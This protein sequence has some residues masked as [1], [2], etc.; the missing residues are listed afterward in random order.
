MIKLSIDA[1][2]ALAGELGE[3]AGTKVIQVIETRTRTFVKKHCFEAV[4]SDGLTMT[5]TSR[6]LDNAELTVHG[7]CGTP[8]D[9]VSVEEFLGRQAMPER[10]GERLDMCQEN[11]ESTSAQTELDSESDEEMKKL[12]EAYMKAEEEVKGRATVLTEDLE[13]KEPA[14]NGI[15]VIRMADEPVRIS[16]V[17][18]IGLTTMHSGIS[19]LWRL[20]TH[21]Q[22]KAMTRLRDGTQAG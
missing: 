7:R 22:L 1:F 15:S 4:F 6:K 21:E 3:A 14:L 9:S 20:P 8:K 16:D 18:D 5:V 13:I 12:A 10:P 19:G 17:N 2:E 11:V